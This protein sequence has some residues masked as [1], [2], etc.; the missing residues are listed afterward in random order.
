M[1]FELSFKISSGK[2]W[3]IFS[4]FLINKMME[5]DVKIGK[6]QIKIVPI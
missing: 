5:K 2:G 1:L 6:K 3:K 4:F